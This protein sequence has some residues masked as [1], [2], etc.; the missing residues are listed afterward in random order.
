MPMLGLLPNTNHTAV[1]P[2][3]HLPALSRTQSSGGRCATTSRM[4]RWSGTPFSQT[5]SDWVLLT[6]QYV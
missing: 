2:L 1:G 3:S 6:R 4:G 5:Q